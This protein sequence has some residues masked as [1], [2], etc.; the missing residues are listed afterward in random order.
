MPDIFLSYSRDDQATARRFAEAFEREGLSVWWDQTLRSGEAYDQV[1]EKALKEA[2]A[3]VV[4]WSKRS[5]DSR[6][7]RAEA[8]L[9]D[10]NKTL[11][12]VMI[13][14]CERPIMFELTHTADL[15]HWNGDSN[16][17][18]WLSYLADVRRF[19]ASDTPAAQAVPLPKP[20]QPRRRRN[21][22]IAMAAVSL[23]AVGAGL[24]A[25]SRKGNAPAVAAAST[26]P[27]AAPEVTLAVLPFADMSPAKDQEYFSDG[28]SEEIL[29]QLA[30]IKGLAVT[31]RT[32]SFSFKGRNE[33]MRV[34]GE[35]L[36]VA[37][38][39]EG[40]VRK[41][42]KELRITAQLINSRSGAHLWSQTY[43]RKLSGVFA[44]QEEIAKD[45]TRALSIKLDVGDMSRAR[46]GTT[47]VE[48]YDRFLQARSLLHQFG[49]AQMVRASAL[50]REALA[51]DPAFA[52]AWHGLY[53]TLGYSLVAFPGK[54]VAIRKEMEQASTRLAA[55]A[56]DAWWTR[57]AHA[58]QFM[59]KRQWREAGEAADAA[60]L[61]TSDVDALAMHAAFLMSVG[62]IDE[63]VEDLQQ[64]RRADPLS[65][66]ISG[67][68]QLY[69]DVA[70]RPEEAQS[71]FE[72]SK[73]LA[74][75]HGR[76]EWAAFLRLWRRSDADPV[77]V[78]AALRALPG[79]R[80]LEHELLKLDKPVP[81]LAAIRRAFNETGIDNWAPLT[82]ISFYADHYG[83]EELALTAM[84]RSFLE[85]NKVNFEGL[86]WPFQSGLR[87]DPRFKDLLRELGLADYF[88][89]SGNWGHFCRP[90]GADDF[91]CH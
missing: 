6:W 40:S 78:R 2:R 61:G 54:A 17:R 46:G 27:A 59:L 34:I 4:L 50:Y 48:A 75:D 11:M 56:P 86:W 29:N 10:R 85:F 32:S 65:L 42:G 38:L 20:D 3:V 5:V 22:G 63:A 52:L 14:P 80:S 66:R 16:D 73:D 71:E 55:L 91:E 84:R 69:L 81:A 31:A 7:V 82:A 8:T 36:G 77:A 43:D 12:P 57:A 23:L 70:D 51:I 30:Q 49:A 64:A 83:D 33:D 53:T 19:V 44:L 87:A 25:L 24:W 74:G 45:V 1:T 35:K 68:L 67:L 58:D 79:D 15:G 90:L 9:A 37:N 18:A 47:D 28:L 76:P 21:L 88:R 13:E 62:R 26:V 41:E 39:L 89:S 72:R 60:L